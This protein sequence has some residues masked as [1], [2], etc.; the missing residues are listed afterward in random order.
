MRLSHAVLLQ[1]NLGPQSVGAVEGFY[2]HFNGFQL[3]SDPPEP[4]STCCCLTQSSVCVPLAVRKRLTLR[5]LIH[6]QATKSPNMRCRSKQARLRFCQVKQKGNKPKPAEKPDS[7]EMAAPCRA[8]K[9][10][11]NKAAQKG[12]K[13]PHGPPLDGGAN[14]ILRTSRLQAL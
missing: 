12:L 3:Q 13:D 2:L 10:N 8:W 1:T 4:L 5:H 14:K 6:Q 7:P 9:A 11:S